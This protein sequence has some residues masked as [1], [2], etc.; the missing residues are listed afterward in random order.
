MFER[1]DVLGATD[2][3]FTLMAHARARGWDALFRAGVVRSVWS[4]PRGFAPT[5]S[6]CP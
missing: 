6:N 1:I 3:T 5:L 4:R 2:F